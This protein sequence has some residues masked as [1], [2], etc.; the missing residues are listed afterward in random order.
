MTKAADNDGMQD[1]A[2][3]YEGEGGERVVNNNGKTK[4]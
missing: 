4:G 1:W 2:S 3:D